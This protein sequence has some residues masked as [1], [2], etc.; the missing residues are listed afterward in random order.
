MIKRKVAITYIL[1]LIS[2]FSFAQRNTFDIVGKVTD[3]E[4]CLPIRLVQVSIAGSSIGDVTSRD[5]TF[6]IRNLE[7]RTYE[8][9]ISHIG[10]KD[11]ILN[12]KPTTELIEAD[13][14]LVP[15][16]TDLNGVVVS[17]NSRLSIKRARELEKFKKLVFGQ[18]Y[19]KKHIFFKNKFEIN[20]DVLFGRKKPS[21]PITLSIENNLL[22]YQLDYVGFQY[23]V[24]RRQRW[25]KGFTRYREMD[26][27]EKEKTEWEANR[28]DAYK[29]SLRHFFKSLREGKLNEEGFI[30]YTTNEV[31]NRYKP[32][33]FIKITDPISLRYTPLEVGNVMIE[34]V[35]DGR[36]FSISFDDAIEI[37][38]NDDTK[39]IGRSILVLKD[40]KVDVYASGELLDPLQIRVF[41]ELGKRGTY[42]MLPF[43]YKPHSY[44]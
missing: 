28:L 6:A 1:A 17:A 41:G 26:G 35:P 7:F 12:I 14:E 36:Y 22:G 3:A 32:R 19:K 5:G 20:N 11:R 27:T 37:F 38:Y 25:F 29:G 9:I 13:I 10:Y 2:G 44:D 24:S 21:E 34:Y 15:D 39:A 43:N 4:T 31:P 8:L 42:E 23:S 30:A 16:I 18:N 33:G 40:K